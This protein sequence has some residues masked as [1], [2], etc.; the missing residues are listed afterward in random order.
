MEL[1][2]KTVSEVWSSRPGGDRGSVG[3]AAADDFAAAGVSVLWTEVIVRYIDYADSPT[4]AHKLK[5]MSSN[6][7]LG[8]RR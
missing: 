2:G 6:T 7:C 1:L 8:R 3:Q 4:R 5:G